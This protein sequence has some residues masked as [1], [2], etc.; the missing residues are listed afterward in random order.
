[1]FL[2]FNFWN[3]LNVCILNT[4]TWIAI[5]K[6]GGHHASKFVITH[7]NGGHIG[8]NYAHTSLIWPYSLIWEVIYALCL[9]PQEKRLEIAVVEVL[10]GAGAGDYLPTFSRHRITIETLCQLTDDDLKQVTGIKS[11]GFKFKKLSCFR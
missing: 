8:F 7:S 9:P 10:E 1:M 4:N 5:I 2:W 3:I 11:Y 6:F